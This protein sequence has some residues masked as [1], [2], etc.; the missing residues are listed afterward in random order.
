MK[1][2]LFARMNITFF[3]QISA[4]IPAKTNQINGAVKLIWKRDLKSPIF[5]VSTTIGVIQ[6]DEQDWMKDIIWCVNSVF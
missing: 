6:Y 4:E 3:L 1:R 2:L 5:I